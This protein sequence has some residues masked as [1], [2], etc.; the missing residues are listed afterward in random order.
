PREYI[1]LRTENNDEVRCLIPESRRIVVEHRAVE[2]PFPGLIG[3]PAEVILQRYDLKTGET[4]RVAGLEC[5]VLT[6]E[7]RDTMRYGYRLCVDRATGLLLRAQTL[8]D[9]REVLEQVAF[10]DIRIGE[11]IDRSR[12]KPAWATEGWTVERSEYTHA[13][14]EKAGWVV[15][16]PEGFRRTKEVLRR[17]GAADAMQVVFS[18]GLATMSV[19][20][21]PSATGRTAV[22]D[23]Q[24]VGPTAAYSRRLGDALVTVIGEV[25]PASVRSVAKSV[26]FRGSK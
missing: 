17:L 6:L 7:P 4:E 15:P 9:R 14:L 13:D 11:R 10:T 23:L 8:G 21:E 3:A 5:Q 18:D 1:R 12:L 20:I 26:E 2:D 25:P 19:F 24:M 16:T 22:E